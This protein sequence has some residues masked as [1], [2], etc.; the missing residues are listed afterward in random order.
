MHVVCLFSARWFHLKFTGN[1][2][3]TEG[4]LGNRMIC[5]CISLTLQYESSKWTTIFGSKQTGTLKSICDWSCFIVSGVPHLLFCP[6]KSFRQN[7]NIMH[8]LFLLV[9][10]TAPFCLTLAKKTLIKMAKETPVMRMMT[11][12]VLKM[13]K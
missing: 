11:M 5:R 9:R 4:E 10:I 1:I 3:L 7:I 13:T 12:M 8:W 6:G 2:A